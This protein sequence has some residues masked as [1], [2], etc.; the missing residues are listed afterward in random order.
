MTPSEQDYSPIERE[1]LAQSFGMDQFRFY[2]VG[3]QF[4]SWTDHEPLVGIY[5]NKQKPATKRIKKHRNN[6][7]DLQYTMCHLPGKSMPCDYGSRNPYP[8]E[9]LTEKEQDK[10]GCDTGREIYV[11]RID[12]GSMP[13]A[14][15]INDIRTAAARDPIYQTIVKD[16]TVRRKASEKIPLGYKRVWQQLSVI[17]GLLHK[18]S[19]LVLPQADIYPG[20]DTVRSRAIDI[21]HEGH[22]GI[23]AMKQYLRSRLWFPAMDDVVNELCKSCL[24]C[25]ASIEVKHRD[26]LIPSTAPTEPWEKL[27]TD[28]WGP[29]ADG[30]YILVVIDKLSRYPEVAIVNSTSAEENIEAFDNIFTRHGYCKDLTSDNGPPFNGLETHKLQQYF[31]WAGIKHSPTKS[32]EDPEANGLAEALMKHFQKIW[33]TAIVEGKNPRAEINRH[34][35]MVRT[36]PHP[37]TKKTP[38]EILFGRKL[39]T[40]LPISNTLTIDRPDIV[41]AIEQ[42]KKTKEQQKKHKDSKPYVKH[43]QIAVGD[44]VLLKQQKRK[45]V[46]PYDP[47]PYTVTSIHGHQITGKRGKQVKTRDAQKWKMVNRKP[48][49]NYQQIRQEEALQRSREHYANINSDIG[50]GKPPATEQNIYPANNTTMNDTNEQEPIPSTTNTNRPTRNTRVPRWQGWSTKDGTEF[51]D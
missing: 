29:T 19:K 41:E 1:S 40:R 9:H 18:G 31:K 32:A 12:I 5:N 25:Q 44:Q 45:H 30:K 50:I 39:N 8:I 26:P 2:L 27:A 21:A 20:G 13:D 33:H 38:A 46:P 34:L 51:M 42:D 28:H 23:Q 37:T 35:L 3:G 48:P 15:A 24:P 43:H 7:S 6:I 10:L 17:N 49:T 47:H 16:I 22:P 11:Q 14:I 4:T 36:T